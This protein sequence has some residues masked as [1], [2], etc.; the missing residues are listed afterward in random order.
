MYFTL[1]V[2]SSLGHPSFRRWSTSGIRSSS[3]KRF[4][5]NE[6]NYFDHASHP[7]ESTTRLL[8]TYFIEPIERGRCTGESKSTPSP[9]LRRT[10]SLPESLDLQQPRNPSLDDECDHF[11]R[12]SRSFETSHGFD[13]SSESHFLFPFWI[14]H[15]ADSDSTSVFFFQQ[16]L[17][18][19]YYEQ[20]L[21]LDPKH[22]HLYTNLGSLLKDMGQ[23][24]QAVAM[25][26]RAVDFNPTFVSLDLTPSVF[27]DLCAEDLILV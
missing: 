2:R 18:L 27:Y 16:Q 10:R 12:K 11:D 17:A 21:R 6:S 26:K 15:T 24:P 20:G 1:H 8:G 7:R 19:K 23:L 25:Y 3:K 5:F 22:P 14:A 4:G 13:W 9:L